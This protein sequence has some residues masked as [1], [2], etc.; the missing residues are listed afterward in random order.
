MPRQY[1]G[2]GDITTYF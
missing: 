2:G 1:I